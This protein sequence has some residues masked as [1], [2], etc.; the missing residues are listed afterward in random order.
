MS[1]LSKTEQSLQEKQRYHL[2]I[3][4]LSEVRWT[5][6]REKQLDD[7]STILYC[8]AESRHE[9]GVALIMTRDTSRSLLKWTPISPRILVA[10]FTGRQA[11][12]SV[13]VCNA[14]INVAEVESKEEF[15]HTL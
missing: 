7:H 9:Q 14:P 2:D 3:L 15:Y 12:L 10:R 5:G 8:G 1:Q 11:K 4:A 13:V 6:S